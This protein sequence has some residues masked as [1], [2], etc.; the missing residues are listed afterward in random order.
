MIDI[1]KN[2]REMR[3]YHI[4]FYINYPVECSFITFL[5]LSYGWDY[6]KHIKG[7]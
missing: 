5:S 1:I 6:K 7:V 2:I 4:A 3:L